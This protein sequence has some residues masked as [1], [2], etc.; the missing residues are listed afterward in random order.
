MEC[1]KRSRKNHRGK[2][3]L[4]FLEIHPVYLKQFGGSFIELINF[5]KEIYN[6]NLYQAIRTLNKIRKFLY[7]YKKLQF[8]EI[9]KEELTIIAAGN[10][11][12]Y[13]AY[14]ICRPR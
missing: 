4:I 9:T 12:I 11:P 8:K 13:Q 14:A 7:R 1:I 5:L 3:P 6:I 10:D 2:K